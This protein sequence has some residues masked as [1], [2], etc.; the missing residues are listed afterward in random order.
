MAHDL[1]LRPLMVAKQKV[2]AFKNSL[3]IA[4][5]FSAVNFGVCCRCMHYG[6][7]PYFHYEC[8]IKNQKKQQKMHFVRPTINHGNNRCCMYLLKFD[9]WFA[10]FFAPGHIRYC[11]RRRVS[12]IISFYLLVASGVYVSM[13]ARTSSW[14]GERAKLIMDVRIK[15]TWLTNRQTRETEFDAIGFVWLICGK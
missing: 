12:F 2:S 6:M 8:I 11:R 10:L 5:P 7:Q 4:M 14:K 9:C 1:F 3:S 13:W 15:K